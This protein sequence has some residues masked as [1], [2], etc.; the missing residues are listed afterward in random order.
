[1]FKK[2]HELKDEITVHLDGV[3]VVAEA[4]ESVAA[5]LLRQPQAW[6]R[7]TPIS[8]AVRGPYCMMGVCFDCLAKTDGNSSVQTC[9]VQVREGMRID[10]QYGRPEAMS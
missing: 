1:M 6:S 8:G 3:P 7:T 4:G 2:L 5:F 10:R 9:L